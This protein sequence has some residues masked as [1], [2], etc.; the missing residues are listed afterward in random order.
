MS[1]LAD[2]RRRATHAPHHANEKE[3]AHHEAG[4]AIAAVVLKRGICYVT[5]LEE[6]GKNNGHLGRCVIHGLPSLE[7]FLDGT[8]GLS[9]KAR[10]RAEY[11]A[12]IITAAGPAATFQHRGGVEQWDPGLLADRHEVSRFAARLAPTGDGMSLLLDRWHAE[13]SEIV[14]DHWTAVCAV[15]EALHRERVLSGR[16]VQQLVA[17]AQMRERVS[18]EADEWPEDVDPSSYF[19]P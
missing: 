15:A 13:A 5:I 7:Q 2:L 4:H 3:T 6:G 12:A 17:A 18:G 1:D 9:S 19:T 14:R 10:K 8:H 16:Q 11:D